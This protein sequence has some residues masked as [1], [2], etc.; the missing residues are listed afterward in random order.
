M[1][2]KGKNTGALY[3]FLASILSLAKKFDAKN[4][5][6]MWDFDSND[7]IRRKEFPTYKVDPN[8][9]WEKLTQE[10]KKD[11]LDFKEIYY[12]IMNICRDLGFASYILKG[13]EADDLMTLFCKQ[14]WSEFNNIVVTS[15]ADLYQL[16]DIPNTVIYCPKK[17]KILNEKWFKKEY[18]IPVKDWVWIKTYAGCSS[19]RVPGVKGIGEQ[20]AIKYLLG[21][22]SKKIKDK[23]NEAK[24]AGEIDLYYRLVELPHRTIKDFKLNLRIS[25]LNMEAFFDVCQQNGFNKFMEE[26]PD[27]EKYFKCKGLV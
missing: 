16:L 9:L 20:T 8:K 1:S 7:G 5:I 13:Y 3:G 19:D 24:K 4:T 25:N 2:Y 18:G 6:I 22:A 21:E 23:I 10:E 26:M 11:I 14:Y 17:N 27:F 15:D 12:N